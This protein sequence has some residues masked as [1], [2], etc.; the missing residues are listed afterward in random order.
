MIWSITE[1]FRK[2]AGEASVRTLRGPCAPLVDH[3][4]LACALGPPNEAALLHSTLASRLALPPS[5]SI[6][7]RVLPSSQAVTKRGRLPFA[8]CFHRPSVSTTPDT[9]SCP[10]GK[11][12]HLPAHPGCHPTAWH[13]LSPRR[14][15]EREVAFGMALQIARI[16]ARADG[17]LDTA[18][19]QSST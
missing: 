18:R 11:Q 15:A 6:L 10:L 4:A 12:A 7:A 16:S 17:E 9:R 1:K 5:K 8:S 19:E 2:R 3:G 13:L 14:K